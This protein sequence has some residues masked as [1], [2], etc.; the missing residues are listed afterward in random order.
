MENWEINKWKLVLFAQVEIQIISL[1]V[2][3]KY[4]GAR[5]YVQWI[6]TRIIIPN[7]LPLNIVLSMFKMG[8]SFDTECYFTKK[9]L[10]CVSWEL[11]ISVVILLR[12][13]IFPLYKKESEGLTMLKRITNK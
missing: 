9:S 12:E 5:L 13:L 10:L 1:D 6:R 11:R 2:D 7:E 4:L 8:A 3:K